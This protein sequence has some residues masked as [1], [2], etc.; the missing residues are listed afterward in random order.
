LACSRNKRNLV[1]E[2]NAIEDEVKEVGKDKTCGYFK[3]PDKLFEM[4][5]PCSGKHLEGLK[6]GGC[7]IW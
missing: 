7:M 6:G 4:D 1:K 2:L 3:G 5:H